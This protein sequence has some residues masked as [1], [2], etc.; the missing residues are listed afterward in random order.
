[1]LR[2]RV[3]FEKSVRTGWRAHG[4]P[5]KKKTFCQIYLR[6]LFAQPFFNTIPKVYNMK[7]AEFEVIIT[8]CTS[9][10]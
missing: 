2:L 1:M 3:F 5:K 8:R 6:N 7:L 10:G 9:S 4:Q